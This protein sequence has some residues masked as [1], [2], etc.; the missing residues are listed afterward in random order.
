MKGKRMA[1]VAAIAAMLAGAAVN[2][3]QE[4]DSTGRARLVFR[5]VA[6]AAESQTHD[7]G[8]S[9]I[10]TAV[11]ETAS[12]TL[13]VSFLPRSAAPACG[14]NVG[15]SMAP[16][17]EPEGPFPL[18]MVEG[19][20][21]RVEMDRIVVAYSWKRLSTRGGAEGKGEATLTEDGRALLDYVPTAETS[22][23]CWQNVALEL[24]ASIPEEEGYKERRIGYDLWLVREEDGRRQT[25]RLQLIGKQGEK[26]TFDHG[27]LRSPAAGATGETDIE[28]NVSGS[29]RGRVQPDGTIELLLQAKRTAHAH[30]AERGWVTAAHGEKRVRAGNGETLRLELPPP[31]PFAGAS[32]PAAFAPLARERVALV[33]TPTRLD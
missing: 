19:T 2:G 32:D 8:S 4:P 31:A 28:M 21:R 29:V 14:S 26:V 5:V 11:G 7:I 22:S 25:R 10:D 1:G 20:A 33:L 24:A 16:A 15:V 18:W 27:L 3:S 13:R 12:A 6:T 23:G 30:A 9:G 17:A